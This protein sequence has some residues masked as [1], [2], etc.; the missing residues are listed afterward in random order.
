MNDIQERRE[1]RHL[2]LH[3]KA[4]DM[5]FFRF[6]SYGRKKSKGVSKAASEKSSSAMARKE[7]VARLE[8]RCVCARAVVATLLG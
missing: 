2:L 3:P 6:R 1:K 7:L 8:G 5:G 4:R